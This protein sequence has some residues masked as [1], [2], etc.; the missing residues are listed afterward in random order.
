MTR[1][2]GFTLEFKRE[3]TPD[4]KK[5]VVAFAN[6]EGGTIYLGVDDEGKIVGVSRA[7]EVHLQ[8][9]AMIRNSIKPD[10]TMFTSCEIQNKKGKEIIAV[11]VQRG[12][13]RP[14]YIAEKGLR[15]AGVYVRQGSSSV[16]A[17]EDAIRQMIKETDGDRFETARSIS[18]DLTF[19][20]AKA[21]FAKQKLSFGEV[22]MKTL[23]IKTSDGI[24]TNLGLL[25]SD[26]CMH[27]IKV[28]VFSGTD[29]SEFKDRREFS[30]SLFKQLNSVYEYIDL[31]NKTKAEFSGLQRIDTRDYPE[32]AIREALLNCLVHRDYAASGSILIN[33]YDDRIEFVSIGGLVPGITLG[34]VMLGI[35]QPR[36]EKLAAVFYHLKLVDAYGAGISRILGSYK[37]STAKPRFD[38][39]ENAFVVTLPNLNYQSTASNHQIVMEHLRQH[40]SITRREVEKLLGIG[41]TAAG[42]ILKEM[43]NKKLVKPAGDGRNRRYVLP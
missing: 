17:T 4:L 5:E 37:N 18:Q 12:T 41:Q 22:Q 20:E 10:V 9:V 31:F 11:H 14:Y 30:G 34:D 13:R 40:G 38:V 28:A 25:L 21:A 33:I 3:F 36:N 39:S 2:E 24:Y 27:T 23:G 29:K 15:P 8:A 35:S 42:K 43:V 32:E 7:R 19:R 6:S 1:Q 16:P 26:Q